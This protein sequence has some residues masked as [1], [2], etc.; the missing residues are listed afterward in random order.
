LEQ[1]DEDARE[2]GMLPPSADGSGLTVAPLPRCFVRAAD[3]IAECREVGGENPALAV[4]SRDRDCSG[5]TKWH[6]G[7]TPKE[8]RD[9]LFDL[10]RKKLELEE[11]KS[12]R[13]YQLISTLAGAVVGALT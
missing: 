12:E 1:V 5:Y 8:H 11:R 4:I 6:P 2:S 10:D 9:M 7:Y 13:R 3:L